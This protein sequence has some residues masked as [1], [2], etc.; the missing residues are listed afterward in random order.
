M[1]L[2]GGGHAFVHFRAMSNELNTT[3]VLVC[4]ADK[5][6]T[7]ARSFTND[8]SDAN[9]SYF[10]GT[11][12]QDTF[13]Q[14]FLSGDRHLAHNG[15]PLKPGLFVLTSN[16]ASGLSWTADLHG[17]VGN[18]LRGDGSVHFMKADRLIEAAKYQDMETNRLAVP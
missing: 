7:L 2:A 5:T 10:V 3:K 6:K 9:V 17:G 12:S 15:Q 14:T 4:P 8:L 1:E 13:P 16:N 11:D 18:V